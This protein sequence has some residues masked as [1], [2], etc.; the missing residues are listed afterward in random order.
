MR[1]LLL[2]I[3]SRVSTYF[4]VHLETAHQNELVA[5]LAFLSTV[6]THELVF[7]KLFGLQLDA[8][9]GATDG[10]F[11]ALVLP[12]LV[13]QKIFELFL[14]VIA[15]FHFNGFLSVELLDMFL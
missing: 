1:L 12:V 7:C 13:V 15:L 6:L 5:E 14:T 9:N 4:L 8:A 10:F 11:G 2:L 3:F